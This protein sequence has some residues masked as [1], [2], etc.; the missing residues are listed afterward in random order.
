MNVLVVYAHHSPDSFTHAILE[1]V[2]RG[3]DESPHSFSEVL[4]VGS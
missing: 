1:N 4:R 3:L 2:T